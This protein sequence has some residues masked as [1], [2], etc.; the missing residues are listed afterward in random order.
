MKSACR[1]QVS[2]RKNWPWVSSDPC[3]LVWNCLL[4]KRM[5][6]NKPHLWGNLFSFMHCFCETIKSACPLVT[7]EVELFWVCE[8]LLGALWLPASLFVQIAKF[9]TVARCFWITTSRFEVTPAGVEIRAKMWQ[10]SHHGA[11]SQYVSHK[12]Y[13]L[14][15]LNF[16]R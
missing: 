4:H 10:S 13:P 16:Q 3:F 11:E 12:T 14:K 9:V 8:P 7:V 6:Q 1:L 5:Q 15:N 2:R